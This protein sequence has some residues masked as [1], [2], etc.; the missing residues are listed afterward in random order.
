[1]A[2]IHGKKYFLKK[3][4]QKYS[5]WL[6]MKYKILNQEIKKEIGMWKG[7]CWSKGFLSFCLW[8]SLL[9]GISRLC[10][11]QFSN[12]NLEKLNQIQGKYFQEF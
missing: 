5:I 3:I 9:I 8:S 10:T 6:C 7:K 4:L 2:I 11:Y 12:K 1:M